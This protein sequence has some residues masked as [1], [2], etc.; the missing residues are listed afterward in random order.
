MTE[1]TNTQEKHGD[2]MPSLREVNLSAD[3]GTFFYLGMC[4]KVKRGKI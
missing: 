1:A 4:F 2:I 3:R